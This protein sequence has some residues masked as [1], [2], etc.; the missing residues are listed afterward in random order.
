MHR[1]G[2]KG[3]KFG[4]ERDERKVLIKTLAANL[5]QHG[6]MDTTLPKAKEIR[7]H[8]EKLITKAKIGTLHSR[9]QV[10]AALPNEEIAHKL[11]DEVVPAL[12]AR[13]SGYL[14]I[15]KTGLRKGDGAPLARIEFVD[16]LTVKTEKPK[17]EKVTTKKPLAKPAVKKAP[18][19]KAVAKKK[20]DK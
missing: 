14:R 9:R 12:S 5:I 7:P 11:V 10:I 15:V 18:A 1:H 20:E 2:Y 6:T 13:T 3:R 17:A 8:V 16:D 19:T 4:R